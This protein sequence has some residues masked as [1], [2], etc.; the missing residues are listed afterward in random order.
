MIWIVKREGWKF[1]PVALPTILALIC[2]KSLRVYRVEGSRNVVGLGM[3]AARVLNMT[4][5]IGK[6][7]FATETILVR[8]RCKRV[9]EPKMLSI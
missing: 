5:K 7:V 1:I 4:L 8:D 9:E 6:D 3:R 2:F